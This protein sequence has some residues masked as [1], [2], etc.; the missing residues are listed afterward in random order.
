M[1]CLPGFE[2]LLR[3]GLHPS[4]PLGDCLGISL[5]S[6]AQYGSTDSEGAIMSNRR[7]KLAAGATVSALGALAGVAL[8]TNHGIPTATQRLATGGGSAPVVTS[9]SGAAATPVGQTVGVRTSSGAR[10]P[11]V[12][13]ASGGAHPTA[14]IDD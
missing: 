5:P 2:S 1:I 8:G 6:L 12:T 3:H 7:A 9:A 14:E 4:P 10:P 13:R 11:I